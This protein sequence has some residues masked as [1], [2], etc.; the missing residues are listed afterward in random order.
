MPLYL[1]NIMITAQSCTR[2]DHN[3]QVPKYSSGNFDDVRFKPNVLIGRCSF[4][5]PIATHLTLMFVHIRGYIIELK[6]F[7][8][9][10]DIG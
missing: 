8:K 10:F 2:G 4:Y 6:S 3:C 9:T 1:S 7:N 5:E